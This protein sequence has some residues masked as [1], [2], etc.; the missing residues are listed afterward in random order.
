MRSVVRSIINRPHTTH[1]LWRYHH[2]SS[3]PAP[4]SHSPPQALSLQEER[5][6]IMHRLY[7]T[8]MK[9]N[10]PLAHQFS[11]CLG[12]PCT[13]QATHDLLLRVLSSSN[14]SNTNTSPITPIAPTASVEPSLHPGTADHSATA[15]ILAT[16]TAHARTHAAASPAPM[17]TALSHNAARE[18][19]PSTAP[20]QSENAHVAVPTLPP[21]VSSLRRGVGEGTSNPSEQE[22]L[23]DVTYA[24]G[25]TLDETETPLM[26]CSSYPYPPSCCL[27]GMLHNSSPTT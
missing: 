11:A 21:H 25:S 6:V 27:S 18:H 5:D 19:A 8:L 4:S 13:I 24:C 3:L 16:D 2:L 22:W 12:A 26:H 10:S 23:D 1:E 15:A 20:A 17:A 9:Q 7:I 14:P